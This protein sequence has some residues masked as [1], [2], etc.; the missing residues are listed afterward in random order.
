[1]NKLF[2][3][4]K[5]PDY[6]KVGKII[7]VIKKGDRLCINNYRPICIVPFFGKVIKKTFLHPINVLPP[8]I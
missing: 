3:A 5:F 6:L 1:M 7:P 2:K 4:G 8:E